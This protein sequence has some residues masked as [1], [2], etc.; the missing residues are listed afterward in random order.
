MIDGTAALARA[1]R[2]GAGLRREL[3]NDRG[4]AAQILPENQDS[5]VRFISANAQIERGKGYLNVSEANVHNALIGLTF[6]GTIYDPKDNM[7]ISG[8]F[9]PANSV[10]LAVSAIPLLGQLL[11]NGRDNALIGVTYQLKGPRNNP[12]LFVNPLSIVAPGVFNKVFE[13]KK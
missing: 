9:M 3:Q 2:V 6:D 4:S 13:F 12:Q 1:D 7:N 5:R 10:N 8:T 11:S